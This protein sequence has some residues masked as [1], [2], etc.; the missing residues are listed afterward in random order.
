MNIMDNTGEAVTRDAAS[1]GVNIGGFISHYR[2]RGWL[3]RGGNGGFG[4]S[5][6]RYIDGRGRAPVLDAL[7][8]DELAAKIEAAPS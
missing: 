7:S 8:L 1:W 2:P 3:I 4:F 6:R 5:A